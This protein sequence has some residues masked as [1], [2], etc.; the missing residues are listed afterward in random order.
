[1]V[2]Y[3]QHTDG[4]LPHYDHSQWTF[5]RGAAATM[6]H[7]PGFLD[8]IFWHNITSTHVCH[9]L[10]SAIPF[11]HAPEATIYIRKVLGTHYHVDSETPLLKKFWDLQRDCNFIEESK[12]MDGSGV[13][14]FRNLHGK[15]TSPRDLVNSD[16]LS[17]PRPISK[18]KTFASWLLRSLFIDK[19]VL[20]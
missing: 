17:G 10:I 2:T 18:E 7:S 19:T 4:S 14:F 9:H 13:Y 3:I 15:G 11:Y 20:I 8:R 12:G 16:K 5:A 6:D 1:V